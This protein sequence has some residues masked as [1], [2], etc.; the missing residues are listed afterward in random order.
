MGSNGFQKNNE[1][2]IVEKCHYMDYNDYI[3]GQ[4]HPSERMSCQR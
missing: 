2:P 3:P 1:K 4:M